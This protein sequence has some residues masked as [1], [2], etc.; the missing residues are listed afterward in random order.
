MPY[1]CRQ[2]QI[3]LSSQWLSLG[4][5]YR[6]FGFILCA[7]MHFLKTWNPEFS[8]DMKSRI[9]YTPG[10]WM[11]VNTI[12]QKTWET[13]FNFLCIIKIPVFIFSYVLYSKYFIYKYLLCTCY[14]PRTT[15]ALWTPLVSKMT[16][17]LPSWKSHTPE[18]KQ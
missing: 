8:K 3:T 15:K 2:R 14:V 5:N 4:R 18:N 12:S 16:W 11:T 1:T 17:P 10:E 13:T 9:K 6:W 7:L